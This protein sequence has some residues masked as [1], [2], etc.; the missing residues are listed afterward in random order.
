VLKHHGWEIWDLTE[1]EFNSW[2][3][4]EKKANIRGWLKEAK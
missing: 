2:T 1:Q 3:F 4:E